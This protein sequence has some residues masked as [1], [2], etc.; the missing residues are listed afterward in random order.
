MRYGLEV[1][2]F[3]VNEN[4]EVVIPPTNL[5]VDEF[6]LIIEARG[7]PRRNIREAVYSVLAERER[8]KNRLKGTGL[9]L[10]SR[11]TFPKDQ[12]LYHELMKGR[13]IT[14]SIDWSNMYG[15]L[16][17]RNTWYAGIH[18]S[19]TDERSMTVGNETRTYNGMWN[20]M[21]LF[22]RLEKEFEK[23]ITGADRVPGMYELK[24]NGRIEYRSLPVHLI[25][26]PELL[27]KRL[28]LCRLRVNE[29]PDNYEI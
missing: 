28:N 23:D 20:F 21:E 2:S 1:E 8:I 26:D 4:E 18:V 10:S 5:P 16:P 9:H 12:E 29:R 6:P 25:N 22:I 3:V 14:K 17:D 15:E 11:S 19:F 13:T 24:G 7:R 27:I